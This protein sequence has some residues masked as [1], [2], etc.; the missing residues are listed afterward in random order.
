MPR[1]ES[2]TSI[3]GRGLQN[4]N[5]ALL[6]QRL[7]SIGW[8][9]RIRT[10]DDGA[11]VRCLTTWLLPIIELSAEYHTKHKKSREYHE[12]DLEVSTNSNKA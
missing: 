7:S 10:L 8:G 5:R 11:R 9:G 6:E 1:F 4:V 3:V 2:P 12:L